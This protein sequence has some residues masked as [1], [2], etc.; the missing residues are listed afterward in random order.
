MSEFFTKIKIEDYFFFFVFIFLIIFAFSIPNFKFLGGDFLICIKGGLRIWF[1]DS[2]LLFSFY[3]IFAGILK[4]I[5]DLFFRKK[6]DKFFDK[7]KF[8]YVKNEIK[9]LFKII[10]FLLIDSALLLMILYFLQNNH[11]ELF[12]NQFLKIDKII[13]GVH[14]F[15]FLNSDLFKF[16]KVFDF[17]SPVIIFCFE[18]LGMFL[19]ITLLILFFQR[20]RKLLSSF[21][22][23]N[24]IFLIIALFF[25]YFFPSYSPNNAFLH[26]NKD[27]AKV[28][29]AQKY[30]PNKAVRNF[31]DIVFLEQKE[32]FPISTMPSGHWAWGLFIIYYLYKFNKKTLFITLPFMFFSFIGTIY[33]AMH[34]LI[35]GIVSVFLVFISIK[36]ANFLVK[37]EDKYY[38][39]KDE[40]E[41]KIY[42]R[43]FLFAP[44]ID[45]QKIL[46][47]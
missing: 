25:W 20:N 14:P 12:N 28:L 32:S 31:E 26:N 16:K 42:F 11:Q 1:Y 4:F 10:L 6:E 17:I 37:L 21:L 38:K 47:H 39:G 29:I 5:S 3:F 35:D 36:L 45:F 2:F 30:H 22:I 40:S 46:K 7:N 23:A 24:F 33:L 9:N 19:S 8:K 43:E 41:S 34:Y 27:F 15:L 18:N 44:F 13:T